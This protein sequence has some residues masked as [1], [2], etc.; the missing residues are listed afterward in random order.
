MG[1]GAPG[2]PSAGRAAYSRRSRA[3][4]AGPRAAEGRAHLHVD[5][6]LARVPRRSLLSPIR[7]RVCSMRSIAY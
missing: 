2:D 4:R 6:H 5:R 3:D 1:S 7:Q